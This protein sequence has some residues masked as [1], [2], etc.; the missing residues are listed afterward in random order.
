M[1]PYVTILCGVHK[2]TAQAAKNEAGLPA[3]T[4][5]FLQN[6]PGQHPVVKL[7]A[8]LSQY[9][10]RTAQDSNL[11]PYSRIRAPSFSIQLR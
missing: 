11:I 9:G 7:L 3:Q 8:K 2:D 6:L 5:S 4:S 1:E 10:S